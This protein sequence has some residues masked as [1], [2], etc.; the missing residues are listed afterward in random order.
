VHHREDDG[1]M[2]RD[3]VVVG[4]GIAIEFND[5]GGARSGRGGGRGLS[6]EKRKLGI[7]L[8]S[9]PRDRGINTTRLVART[10]RK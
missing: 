5:G 10:P 2:S 1:T 3:L 7:Q 6:L 8:F 4:E 9:R